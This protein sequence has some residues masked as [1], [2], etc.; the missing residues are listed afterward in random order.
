MIYGFLGDMGSGKT[1][2]M[3]KYAYLYHK[4]GYKIYS[5][6]HLNFPHIK[7]TK[8]FLQQIVK[9]NLEFEGN[10]LFCVDEIDM[11]IDSRMSMKKSNII[12]SYLLKQVRKKRIRLFYTVQYEHMID[13][14]LR[15]LTKTRILCK[16][17]DIIMFTENYEFII[18]MIYNTMVINNVIGQKKRFVGNRYFKLYNTHE[19]I[20]Y[21]EENK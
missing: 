3:T 11:L 4:K 13:K 5:N 21:E 7:I 10:I 2:T 19:L 17:K 14:R 1:L 20:V 15:S 8:E 9:E 16:T 12:L 6:Y 18:K